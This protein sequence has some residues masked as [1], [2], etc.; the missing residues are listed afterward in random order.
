MQRAYDLGVL[1]RA[2]CSVNSSCGGRDDAGRAPALDARLHRVGDL[3]FGSSVHATTVL[4]VGPGGDAEAN[5]VWF[6]ESPRPTAFLSDL[7]FNGTHSY[8]ADGY[9]LS[10][11][12][13]LSRLERLR[14]GMDFVFPG[15]GAAGAPAQLIAAQR[16]Y[17]LTL[18]AHVKELAEE[19]PE[20]SDQAKQELERRMTEYLPGAG[21]TFLIAMNADPVAREL[22]VPGPPRHAA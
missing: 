4:D 21:L 10:W 16:S 11:I 14:A 2:C 9:L 22:L 12:A 6:I 7:V 13:N 1:V 17:L 20:L 18:A 3:D 19:R 15:H 5:S 8:V